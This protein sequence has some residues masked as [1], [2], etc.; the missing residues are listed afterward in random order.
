ME[1]KELNEEKKIPYRV[2]TLTGYSRKY[3]NKKVKK[4][5]RSVC[6]RMFVCVC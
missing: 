4:N 5:V 3:N 2:S 1:A 6:E